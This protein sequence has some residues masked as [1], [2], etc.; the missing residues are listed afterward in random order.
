MNRIV[1]IYHHES[2]MFNHIKIRNHTI[3]SHRID[4]F[5]LNHTSILNPSTVKLVVLY[6]NNPEYDNVK[7][8]LQEFNVLI[9]ATT[10]TFEERLK[11]DFENLKTSHIVHAPVPSECFGSDTPIQH[12]RNEIVKM[13]EPGAITVVFSNDGP[14]IQTDVMVLRHFIKNVNNITDVGYL[15]TFIMKNP[16]VYNVIFVEQDNVINQGITSRL[17]DDVATFLLL[18]VDRYINFETECCVLHKL[19]YSLSMF[20]NR[21][22]FLGFLSLPPRNTFVLNEMSEK[23]PLTYVHMAGLSPYKQTDIVLHAFIHLKRNLKFE[24][25][26]HL[27]CHDA[28]SDIVREIIEEHEVTINTDEPVDSF[29]YYSTSLHGLY[30]TFQRIPEETKD[31]LLRRSEFVVQPS[32]MEG[33]GHAIH[34]SV[35]YNCVIISQSTPYTQDTLFDD[36]N[37]ILVKSDKILNSL[38]L[39]ISFNNVKQVTPDMSCFRLYYCGVDEMMKGFIRAST[40]D[41]GCILSNSRDLYNEQYKTVKK[42]FSRLFK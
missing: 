27:S 25:T 12:F 20:N 38:H 24:G 36:Y 14:S 30:I 17:P 6:I 33:F 21:G 26:L 3:E 35:F 41:R 31:S 39:R 40:C 10:N 2:A 34:Q 5:L 4:H 37:A 42:N 13:I 29:G 22:C 15:S 9:Y 32:V 18:N 19:S 28:V 1:I 23:V 8:Y 16:F 11:K 7:T